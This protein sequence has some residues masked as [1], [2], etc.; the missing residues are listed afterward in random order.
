MDAN[1]DVFTFMHKRNGAG[2]DPIAFIVWKRTTDTVLAHVANTLSVFGPKETAN[3]GIPD[4]SGRWIIFPFNITQTV[5]EGDARLKVLDLQTNTWQTL[6]WTGTEDPT[7]HGDVGTGL[8]VG[9]G[10]FSGAA[11]SRP[12]SN[13]Q[14]HT[15]LF[16]WRDAAG[17]RDWSDDHHMTLYADDESWVTM[18]TINQPG[19]SPDLHLYENEIIQFSPTDAQKFKRLA[20]TRSEALNTSDSN[21][22][23]AGPF[24]TI[25]RDSRYVAYTSNWENSGRTDLFVMLM[26][27]IDEST[28]FVRQHYRDFLGRAGETNGVGFWRN[29]I[30][31]CGTDANCRTAKRENVSAAFFLSIEFQQTGYLAYRAWGAAFGPQR[32]EGRWAL[33]RAEFM[34]DASLLNQNLVVGVQGWEAQLEA[35]KVAYFNAFVARPAFA[36][37]YPA[38]LTNT[39]YVDALNTTS[40]FHLSLA[41]RDQLIADLSNGSKTRAQVLRAV[42]EDSDFVYWQ[43]NRAFV[44][45]EYFGYLRRDPDPGGFDGWYNKLNQFNGDYNAAEMVKAFITSLEYRGRFGQ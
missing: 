42:A 5:V 36:A 7:Y 4:K 26:P 15:Q 39:Q 40:G 9:R 43:N 31:Q 1:D 34:P 12:L 3:A 20:H 17:N 30:E 44:T 24:A 33:T 6:F 32:I 16:N 11:N 22:Y 37:A 35:N 19:A 23:W 10:A 14:S 8:M 27:N 2:S 45:M 25:S 38:W 41:E 18:G 21:G 28:F 29:E 13:L